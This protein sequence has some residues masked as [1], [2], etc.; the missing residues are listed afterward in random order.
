[1]AVM[2]VLIELDDIKEGEKYKD[3]FKG[4]LTKDSSLVTQ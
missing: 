2:D 4:V 1:M 3:A